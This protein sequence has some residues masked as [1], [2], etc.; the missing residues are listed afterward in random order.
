MFASFIIKID[1]HDYV[2]T[3]LYGSI[4]Q[5]KHVTEERANSFVPIRV[6]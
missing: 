5:C 1:A 2:A 4:R 3:A 6:L